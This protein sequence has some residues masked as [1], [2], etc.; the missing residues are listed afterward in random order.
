MNKQ[1]FLFSFA[2]IVGV[3]L[4]FASVP[5]LKRGMG[6]SKVFAQTAPV[7]SET[8]TLQLTRADAVVLALENNR[9][10]KNAYL[11]RIIQRQ[12][13]QQAQ[14]KFRPDFTPSVSLNLNR[15]RFGDL[16]TTDSDLNAGTGVTL[17]IPTGANFNF[18]FGMSG[19][20]S[21]FTQDGFNRNVSVSFNQPLLRNF[22]TEINRSSIKLAQLQERT[23]ILNLKSL[24]INTIT[25]TIATY[26]NLVLAQ[27]SFKIQ[28]L[29]VERAKEQREVTQALIDAGRQP[30]IALIPVE[31]DI[32]N[33]EVGL[34]AARN[35][36]TSAQTNLLQI[37][38][39]DEDVQLQAEDIPTT[40][41]PLDLEFEEQLEI[42]LQNNP[43]YQQN[44]LSREGSQISLLQAEN[45]QKWDL[46]LDVNYNVNQNLDAD[47]NEDLRAGLLLRREFGNLSREN[48]V[49]RS[50]IN[51]QQVEM[52]LTEARDELAIQVQR[53]IRDV[54]L[55]FRQVAIAKEATALA[56]QQLDIEREKL[57]LGVSGVRLI[58]IVELED[59]L[60]NAENGE[61]QAVISY[62]NT[63]T[64][65]DQVLGTTLE[66]WGVT[67][68]KL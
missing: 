42:A 36:L 20:P 3:D 9:Q 57:R 40:V 6:R 16:S 33:R 44:L 64:Q 67:V 1:V 61:R 27:E 28:Q 50:Q 4:G 59:R 29:A 13:L 2:L 10:L 17:Q 51:L 14:D 46:G 5:L 35:S 48:A 54:D 18:N 12:Q 56:Q 53:L 65:L 32:A 37:L 8:A 55:Q 43:N 31:A 7:T 34:L 25:N 23:N 24:L 68:E 60:V 49:E 47:T 11:Q 22:G 19:N 52:S 26:H 21:R 63:L 15:N 45:E 66:R 38:D 39:L 62:L 30:R 58:D 41:E